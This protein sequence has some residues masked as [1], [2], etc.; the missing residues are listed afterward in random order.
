AIDPLSGHGM[1]E[2]I[3]SALAAA[4]VVNTLIKR[5]QDATPARQ[6]FQERAEQ[7][8]LRH[9]RVGRDFYTQERRWST[10]PFWRERQQW[11][12]D[13]PAHLPPLDSPPRIEQRP[14][15]END[16]IVLKEVVVTAHHPRGVWQV[17]GIP[18]IPLQ[19]FLQSRTASIELAARHFE[20]APENA[21]T[22]AEWLR[23]RGLLP[24]NSR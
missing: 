22:A 13:K 20:Q 1:F 5:P 15:I 19:R 21:A 9:C 12:D 7:S 10:R 4:P 6:Y 3:G 14:V 18:L 17:A 8:F 23:F 24:T 11:P 16:F 2:A